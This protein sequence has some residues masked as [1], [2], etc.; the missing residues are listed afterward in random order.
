MS[1][2]L[3]G[4]KRKRGDG[5]SWVRWGRLGRLAYLYSFPIPAGIAGMAL[6]R[7]LASETTWLIVIGPYD[8]SFIVN[9]RCTI[10]EVF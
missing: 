10:S 9:S 7:K 1:R 3:Q 6:L 2:G 5:P 8:Q 4:E